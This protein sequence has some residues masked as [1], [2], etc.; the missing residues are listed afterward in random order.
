MKILI[1]TTNSGKLDFI[2]QVLADLN[3]QFVSL[4]EVGLAGHDVEETGSTYAENAAIKAEYFHG[5]S[6]LP[7]LGEDS[8]II[9]DALANE[10]GVHTRRWGAGAEATDQEWI[11][12]FLERMTEFPDP[13]QRTARFVSHIALKM[14]NQEIVSFQ[15]EAGGVITADL[16]APILPGIPLSSC[17][18]AD[19]SAKVFAAMTAAEKANV[20]HRGKAVSQLKEYLLSL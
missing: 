6:G 7:T 19:G 10:L 11:D 5:L 14:P 18:R 17:F 13:A 12:Y 2:S 20:S 15:G 3:H 16:Q 1:A 4:N 8:G 9:I